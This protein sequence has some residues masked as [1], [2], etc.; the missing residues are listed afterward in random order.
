MGPW[1]GWSV[2]FWGVLY[3][4][5]LFLFPSVPLTLQVFCFW[6][7]ENL[8]LLKALYNYYKGMFRGYRM[9]ANGFVAMLVESKIIND[10]LLTSREAL[11]CFVKVSCFLWVGLLRA[12][13]RTGKNF[14]FEEFLSNILISDVDSLNEDAPKLTMKTDSK[15]SIMVFI[16]SQASSWKCSVMM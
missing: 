12:E 7:Q 6:I 1:W 3:E 10:Q 4:D 14:S 11:Y 9:P 2:E 16:E 5:L 15:L 8:P 13:F